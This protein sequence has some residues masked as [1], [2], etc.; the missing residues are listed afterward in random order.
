VSISV[1]DRLADICC[2]R[3]RL[4]R[5]LRATYAV[6]RR[7]RI[8]AVITSAATNDAASLAGVGLTFEE[9]RFMLPNHVQK[10]IGSKVGSP[11]LSIIVALE[12]VTNNQPH[13][14]RI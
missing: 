6:N 7:R 12:N 5:T 4:A 2:A 11:F 13:G 8:E 9:M 3:G 10:F 1:T 14:A